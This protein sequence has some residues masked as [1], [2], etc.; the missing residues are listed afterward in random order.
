MKEHNLHALVLTEHRKQFADCEVRSANWNI[1]ICGCVGLWVAFFLVL[2]FVGWASIKIWNFW[3]LALVVIADGLSWS[4]E[5]TLRFFNTIWFRFLRKSKTCTSEKYL[6]C[7]LVILVYYLRF[8]NLLNGRVLFMVY[9]FVLESLLL[10]LVNLFLLVFVL[11]SNSMGYWI[12]IEFGRFSF[13]Y[14]IYSR[15]CFLYSVRE[16]SISHTIEQI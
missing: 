13:A 12:L 4:W 6:L 1:C 3:V 9:S 2:Y 5:K 15:W 14:I 10:R 16:V 8:T 11:Y 7:Q